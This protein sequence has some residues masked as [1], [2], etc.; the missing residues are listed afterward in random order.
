MA[1]R[2]VGARALGVL[3]CMA[4]AVGVVSG[5][6]G[7]SGGRAI[8]EAS[9]R[10]ERAVA[11]VTERR[12]GGRLVA[13]GGSGDR[14][15][16]VVQAAQT[17]VIDRAASV[18]AD[19]K[20]LVFASSR[21][22]DSVHQSSLWVA[23]LDG[24]AG[25]PASPV[26][27]T[28]GGAIDTDPVWLAN[29]RTVVFASN[30]GG[31]FDLW[32]VEAP[33]AG[34]AIEPQRLTQAAG[35]ELMPSARPD[36]AVAYTSI[37]RTADGSAQSVIEVRL[38]DGTIEPWTR[39]PADTTPTFGAAGIYFSAPHARGDAVDA[40]IAFIAA[41]GA[42]P[43]WV[44]ELGG[45]DESGPSLSQDERWIFF[46]SVVRGEGGKPVWSSVAHLDQRETPP[47][48]RMLVDRAGAVI[49]SSPA[50]LAG[51]HDAAALHRNPPYL[52]ELVRIHA[53][54]RRLSAPSEEATPANP[55]GPK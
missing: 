53:D 30:R 45:T 27:L 15:Y 24:P 51:P 25:V 32:Q 38:P 36:G 21:G 28:V 18:S 46:T 50:A 16:E 42:T 3:P 41:P 1:R 31:T 17:S 44:V 35:D 29:G 52:D 26:R 11:I 9:E 49:R 14:L 20:R 39:G 8:S 5:C 54:L 55:A 40:D 48:A 43:R 47:Q 10:Q 34:A 2:L 7:P 13:I 12:A 4:I 33:L 23:A 22:R 37:V 19:G 6:Q